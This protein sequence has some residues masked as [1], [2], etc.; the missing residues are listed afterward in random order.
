[1]PDIVLATVN[2]RFQHAAF[3]LRYLYANL[4]ELRERAQICEWSLGV[5]E[6]DV[7]EQ[8]LALQPSIV[9][10]SVFIWNVDIITRVVELLKRISPDISLVIGGPEV[11]FEWEEMPIYQVCDYLVRGEG[12]L[13]FADLCQGL[14]GGHAPSEKVI[15]GG[16]PPLE[17]LAWPYPYYSDFDLKHGRIVYVEASRGCPFQ[18]HFCL[19]S[20][21]KKVRAFSLDSFLEEME[22]LMAR[23][24][25]RFK[26]VDRTFNLKASTSHRILTFFLDRYRDGMFLHFEMIP[27][28]LPPDL[29][30]VIASFPA[31]VLQFEV[32]IQSFNPDVCDRIGRRQNFDAIEENLTFLAE[33]TGVHVHADLIAGLPGED[34]DS[35]AAGFDRLHSLGVSE[36]QLGILKRLRGTPIT[37]ASE[38]WGMVYSPEAPYEVV[39]TAHLK[40]L[41][42]QRLQRFSR[43]WD[44]V[45]N[46]GRFL[47]I[48]EALLTRDSVFWAFE[49]FC[50]WL[51]KEIGETH[52]ISAKRLGSLLTEYLVKVGCCSADRAQE[53][54]ESDRCAVR[55]V[56][57]QLPK[58][59]ARH[60]QA[61]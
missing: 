49:S 33:H 59:Q 43:Y 6:R 45:V 58:R 35:F 13:A 7:A 56:R 44:L 4:G 47:H 8:I 46:S 41:E 24:V 29:R 19:S 15:P 14:L 11:S 5:R 27:D 28:R 61:H 18:C 55:A 40:F 26:F 30:P 39:R 31:G 2:A 53:L 25:L 54:L 34:L 38:E 17:Q 32:G 10:F 1:M 20:L 9:G 16:L 21:D 36:I 22:A 51:Y 52:G 3:G 48:T 50:N 60:A 42:L 23:G 37:L 57:G 12:E